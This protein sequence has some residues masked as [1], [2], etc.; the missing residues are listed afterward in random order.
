MIK[1]LLSKLISP[2]NVQ[3]KNSKYEKPF[4]SILWSD[5]ETLVQMERN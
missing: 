3:A 1:N 2:L 4:K 5:S